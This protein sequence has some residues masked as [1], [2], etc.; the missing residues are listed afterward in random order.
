MGLKDLLDRANIRPQSYVMVMLMAFLVFG[1]GIPLF[2]MNATDGI[3]MIASVLLSL[4]ILLTVA[5]YPMLKVMRIRS[6]AQDRLP[7]FVTQMAALSTSGMSAKDLFGT[8]SRLNGFG[9]LSEDAG[10]IKR[11]V[12]EHNIPLS[13][14]C[15][16]VASN[17]CSPHEAAFLKAFAHSID[18][19]QSPYVFLAGEQKTMMERFSTR[20]DSALAEMEFL[21]EILVAI[22]TAM[23]FMMVFTI[24]I[25]ILTD[26]SAEGI[27]IIGLT[28]LIS[29]EA[30]FVLI[31][32]AK[33][34][35]DRIWSRT[36]GWART[37]LVFIISA[38]ASV[39]L[40]WLT[41]PLIDCQAAIA[42]SCVPMAI[43][44]LMVLGEE[45][46]I[47]SRDESFGPFIRALGRSQEVSEYTLARSM[48][49]LDG[50]NFDELSP[51][52]ENMTRRVC[53]DNDSDEAWRLFSEET[54]SDLIEN[55]SDIYRESVKNG[56]SPNQTS[57][58]INDNHTRVLAL[59]RRKLVSRSGF[60]GVAYGIA[61]ALAVT[62]WVTVCI[63]GAID[64]MAGDQNDLGQGYGDHIQHYLGGS[65][66]DA[67]F[68][69]A[70]SAVMIIVHAAA[71]ALSLAIL[72]GGKLVTS[73]TH[74]AAMTILGMISWYPV[75]AML[76]ILLG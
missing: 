44:G 39:I 74:F 31:L 71:S 18:L 36:A 37:S 17:A 72:K 5:L 68:V 16:I 66:M 55:F 4:L 23:V 19:G 73:T 28:V 6:T 49:Q 21:R 76:T 25:P 30:I 3:S 35:R 53:Y 60:L 64:D 54:G 48:E 75:D 13:E 7:L 65:V 52:V 15:R 59:R 34:P 9:V 38:I 45:K 67:S 50:Q 57:E 2:L 43:P 70:V 22:S 47:L 8:M 69:T 24:L 14:A 40:L 27:A 42:I 63:I 12:T 58:F 10:I 51:M 41:L 62:M 46:S 56:A 11:M 1:L 61:L 20:S 33:L 32:Q 26:S 29:V